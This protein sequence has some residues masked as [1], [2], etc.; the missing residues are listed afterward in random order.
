M[1]TPAILAA[2]LLMLLPA[3]GLSQYTVQAYAGGGIAAADNYFLVAGTELLLTTPDLVYI[4]GLSIVRSTDNPRTVTSGPVVYSGIPVLETLA[5][6]T[7]SR[8]TRYTLSNRIEW[9]VSGDVQVAA[10]LNAAVEPSTLTASA[11]YTYNPLPAPTGWDTTLF[12]QSR[13]TAWY[14]IG[15]PEVSV[16]FNGMRVGAGMILVNDFDQVHTGQPYALLSSN[17]TRRLVFRAWLGGVIDAKFLFWGRGSVSWRATPEVE[18]RGSLAYARTSFVYNPEQRYLNF[19]R[20]KDQLTAG[21]LIVYDVAQRFGVFADLEYQ[22][23]ARFRMITVVVGV[24][25]GF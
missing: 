21:G 4:P 18:L 17:P 15:G 20:E 23:N 19:Y 13:H 2:G 16:P 9:I 7:T 11:R 5:L 6:S 25:A 10:T 12:T 14:I 1:R 24:S 22:R 3:P 8:L